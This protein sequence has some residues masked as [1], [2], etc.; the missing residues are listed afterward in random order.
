M[1]RPS[2]QQ[3]QSVYQKAKKN[4]AKDIYN[5]IVA[6]AKEKNPDFKIKDNLSEY[7]H[8]NHFEAFAEIFANSQ[9][10][11]PNELGLAMQEWLKKEEF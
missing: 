2:A 9:C 3:M 8:T 11:E 10:G 6:I 4:G 1:T 5:E 7:G